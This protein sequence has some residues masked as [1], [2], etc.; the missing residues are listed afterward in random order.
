VLQGVAVSFG[1][2]GYYVDYENSVMPPSVAVCCRVFQCVAV[3]LLDIAAIMSTLKT[4]LCHRV[5]QC[6]AACSSVLQYVS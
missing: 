5:L 1:Y 4:V 2:C 3:C 6:V